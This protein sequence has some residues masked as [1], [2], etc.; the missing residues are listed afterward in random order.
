[1]ITRVNNGLTYQIQMHS[2]KNIL[3]AIRGP[4]GG[5]V[6]QIGKVRQIINLVRKVWASTI[7]RSDEE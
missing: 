7:I 6:I 1:M 2:A 4:C 5:T 3:V